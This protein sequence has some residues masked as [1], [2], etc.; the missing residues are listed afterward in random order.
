[1]PTH[2]EL[3]VTLL[4]DA[5][6][7]FRNVAESNAT[8]RSQMTQHADLFEHMARVMSEDPMGAKD[9]VSH[10]SVAADMMKHAAKFFHS[11]AEQNE[12]IGE[13]MHASADIYERM[14]KLVAQ[15]PLGVTD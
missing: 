14:S 4:N 3:T 6:A 10:A 9:N 1:M 8:V 13:Q 7:F 5:A 12:P 2:A 15:D 11:V